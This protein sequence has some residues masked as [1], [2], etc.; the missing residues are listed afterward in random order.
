[1]FNLISRSLRPFQQ[2]IANVG[3]EA[4]SIAPGRSREMQPDLHTNAEEAD[5][6]VWLHCKKST[7]RRKLAFSP[8]TDVYHIGLS[9]VPHMSDSEVIVQL[10]NSHES[11]R[12]LSINDPLT[13][14]QNDPDLSRLPLSTRPQALQSLYVASGCDY[15]SF[16][17]GIGKVSFSPHS[18]STPHSSLEE[19]FPLGQW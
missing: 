18:T 13:A 17:V 19:L 11:A 14:L 8:D 1:M 5:L 3:E 16:F 10:N 4:F 15:I 7:G 12:H 6:R 2:F 9:E